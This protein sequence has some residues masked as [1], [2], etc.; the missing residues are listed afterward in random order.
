MK[1]NATITI[2]LIGLVAMIFIPGCGKPI[3]HKDMIGTYKG[4]LYE[5]G[6]SIQVVITKD[7]VSVTKGDKKLPDEP[8]KASTAS[9]LTTQSSSIRKEKDEIH[10]SSVENAIG[11]NLK[12]VK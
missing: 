4:V 2:M 9:S 7:T 10:Y 1:K 12:K 5:G 3:N 6:P 11:C 8:I